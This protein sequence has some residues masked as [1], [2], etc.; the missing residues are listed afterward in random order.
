M[1]SVALKISDRIID[2]RLM[3]GSSMIEDSRCPPSI[4]NGSFIKLQ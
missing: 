1:E 3:I 4:I 2:D